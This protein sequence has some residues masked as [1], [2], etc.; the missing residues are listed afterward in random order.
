MRRVALAFLATA[1]WLGFLDQARA[2]SRM[3]AH[4]AGGSASSSSSLMMNSSPGFSAFNANG[5]TLTNGM[6]FGAGTSSLM[7]GGFGSN[8]NFAAANGMAGGFNDGFGMGTM[9][10]QAAMNSVFNT[11][12]GMGA[13][14]GQSYAQAA[15]NDKYAFG[16]TTNDPDAAMMKATNTTPRTRAQLTKVKS[17]AK[18]KTPRKSRPEGRAEAPGL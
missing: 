15:R 5:S 6:T 17:R 14:N 7:G 12:Y 13:M 11:G 9:N 8:L 1:F 10:G 18:S 4:C 2:Q 16:N 3:G